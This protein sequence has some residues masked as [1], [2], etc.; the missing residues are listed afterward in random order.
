V[1]RGRN[2]QGKVVVVTGANSGLGYE[3]C[4]VFTC[5]G[6]HVVGLVRDQKKGAEFVSSIQKDVKAKTGKE[7]KVDFM[8][9]DLNSLASVRRFTDA[10]IARGLPIHVLILNAGLM[11]PPVLTTDDGFDSQFGVNHI[12]HHLLTTRLL[13]VLKR[14]AP[15][16]VVVLSSAGHMIS[17]I[18]WEDVLFTLP[19]TYNKWVA[20]GQSKTANLLFAK[21]LNELMR[22]QNVL[23]TVNA[24][25]PGTIS[26]GLKR[27]SDDAD[28]KMMAAYRIRWKTVP[29]GAAGHVWVA[30]APQFETEGGHYA[31]G[32]TLDQNAPHAN[33][34][35]AAERLWALTERMIA[36]GPSA[37]APTAEVRAA[38]AA[39]TAAVPAAPPK[40]S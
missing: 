27:H 22:R 18:R 11:V 10:Y 23:V 5:N 31:D 15:A 13:D 38:H 14:S 19:G 16:R 39:R 21:W 1:I 26:T 40:T 32:F 34:M 28:A 8:L 35:K 3:T 12:A 2:V 6:A 17:G 30:T 33:D 37:A 29:Q 24:V 7:G 36:E 4:R 25:H 9:C 20:Y